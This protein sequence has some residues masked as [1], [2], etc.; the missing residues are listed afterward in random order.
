MKVLL[1]V[2]GVVLLIVFALGAWEV[3]RRANYALSYDAM[4]RQ[5]VCDMV[6][7]EHLRVPCPEQRP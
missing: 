2:L 3:S 5:T 4:V 1:N 7:P 6:K